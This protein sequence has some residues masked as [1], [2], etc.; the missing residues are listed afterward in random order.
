MVFPVPSA[1]MTLRAM[2]R[3]V[4]TYIV[5]RCSGFGV[6][7]R[8]ILAPRRARRRRWWWWWSRDERRRI[9]RRR[10]RKRAY[11]PIDGLGFSRVVSSKH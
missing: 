11:S 3:S 6:P 10:R 4:R 2:C 5:W 1:E 8:D 9:K 7:G